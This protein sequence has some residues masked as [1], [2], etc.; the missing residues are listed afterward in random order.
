MYL[1]SCLGRQRGEADRPHGGDVD[2]SMGGLRHS[3][4]QCGAGSPDHGP[5]GPHPE[6]VC[7]HDP[8]S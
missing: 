1:P 3:A 6:G 7:R 5:E 2:P 4:S 8:E